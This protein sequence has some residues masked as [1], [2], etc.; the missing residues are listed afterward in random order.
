MNVDP[1]FCE[2]L[3]NSFSS[4]PSVVVWDLATDMMRDVGLAD[5]M[6]DGS[7]DPS[8]DIANHA[9]ATH[10][11]AIKGRESTTGKIEG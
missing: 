4:L 7:A 6:S 11:F 3:I 2:S 5:A 8:C 1:I 9:W 10:E